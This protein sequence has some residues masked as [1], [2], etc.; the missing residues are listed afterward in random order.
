M[1]KKD[2]TAFV[3][4]DVQ[5]KL[6]EMVYESEFM[7]A[8]LK[9]LIQGLKILEIPII[10][11]EQYPVG[12]GATTEK[13]SQYL[14]DQLPIQK[15]TFNGCKSEAFRDAVKATE[16]SQMLVAGIEAHICVYQT[17]FGLKSMGYEVEV[18]KDAVSSRTLAN[19]EIGFE[20]IKAAGIAQTGV[21]TALFELM[22]IAEGDQFKQIIKLLK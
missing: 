11:L 4:V 7:I 2:Q 6:A 20:K 1:L 5:G 14:T 9:K 12:L 21:E 13:I 18:C 17:A 16:R 15:M 10:W 3:L 22:E 8:N 19:K